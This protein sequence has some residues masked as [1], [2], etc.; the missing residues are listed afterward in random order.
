MFLFL[1]ALFFPPAPELKE[2][3]PAEFSRPFRNLPLCG[4]PQQVSLPQR[5]TLIFSFRP[6]SPTAPTTICLPMT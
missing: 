4:A 3:R 6:S 2:K 5:A 1:R